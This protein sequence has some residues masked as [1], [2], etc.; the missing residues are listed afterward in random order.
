MSDS[1]EVYRDK[2]ASSKSI[3]QLTPTPVTPIKYQN[4]DINLP[5]YKSPT[6]RVHSHWYSDG[7]KNIGM[8]EEVCDF[9]LPYTRNF[10]VELAGR[11]PGRFNMKQICEIFDYCYNNWHYVNDPAGTEYVARA[12]ESIHNSLSGDCDDFAVL[13]AS[14]IIAIGGEASIITA[15]RG[16]GRGHAYA[17]VCISSFSENDVLSVVRARF[18]QYNISSLHI[19]SHDG[20]TWLNL[21]WQAGYPGGPYW[22]ST[23]KTTYVYSASTNSWHLDGNSGG[24]FRESL[25]QENIDF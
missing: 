17:E 15:S 25:P 14:C 16:D 6:D 23:R 10:A 22:S 3:A 19:S 13:M 9:N 1:L 18:P 2:Y 4:D 8:L 11:A 12:S 20:K 24:Y 7:E 21:D 5:E